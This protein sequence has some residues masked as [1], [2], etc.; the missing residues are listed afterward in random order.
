MK[1]ERSYS[2]LIKLNTFEDRFEYCALHGIVGAETFGSN[3]FMNQDFYRRP[4]WK[5]ARRAVILRDN[6]CD[7]GIEDREILDRIYIHHLNP[8]KLEDLVNSSPLLFDLE[9]LICVSYNTHQAIHYGD[10][11]LLLHDYVP[12]RPNDT[13]PWKR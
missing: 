13:C 9:N 7:L 10:S 6:G 4:E 1:M 11:S 3:R 2:E 8:V 5:K 12:R